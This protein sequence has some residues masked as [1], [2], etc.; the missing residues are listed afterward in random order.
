MKT[1]SMKPRKLESK[2]L[3]AKKK[4]TKSN[5]QKRAIST[6]MKRVTKHNDIRHGNKYD[7]LWDIHKNTL[8]Y[9]SRCF[10]SFKCSFVVVTNE[11]LQYVYGCH[12]CV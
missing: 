2:A 1:V 6:W 11:Q 5:R 3:A 10:Q 4:V 7:F 9:R 12:F 8:H